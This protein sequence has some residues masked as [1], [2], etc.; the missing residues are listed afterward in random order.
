MSKPTLIICGS[1]ALDR[2]MNF[3]GSYKDLIK[4]DKLHVLSVS[5]LLDKMEETR[6]GIAANIAHNLALLGDSPI[7]LGSVGPDAAP[8][9]KEL[10]AEGIN[11]TSVHTSHLPTASFNVMTDSD[12]NQVGGFYPGAM[13]DSASLSLKPWA[14]QNVLVC[15]SAHDPATMKA[16]VAECQEYSLP[17]VYDPGQQV[18]NSPAE[19]LKQG[20]DVAELLI[21]NDYELGVLCEKTGTTPQDIKAKI[22]IVIT[23]FGK[24][25]SVIEGTRLSS[26]IKIS[27][28]KPIKLTDPTGAGDAYRAGFLYGYLRQWQLPACGQLGAVVASFIIEHHGTQAQ[29]SKEAIIKR[30]QETFNQEITL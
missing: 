27:A 19:D 12:D 10:A 11:I 7:L 4:P 14:S 3:S 13:A 8:Y 23:T 24:D 21:V 28:A 9:L 16:Q 20:I 1:V 22:P 5:V 30:Y 25:G 29:L 18:S 26:P 2:I 17:L 6:G 15:I